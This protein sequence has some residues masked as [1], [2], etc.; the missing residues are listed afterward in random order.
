MIDR[1]TKMISFRMSWDE[2]RALQNACTTV[3]VRNLSELARGAM[4]QLIA[5]GRNGAPLYDQVC[6]LR[7]QM[8]L[9]S[10]E[11][12]RIIERID[13]QEKVLTARFSAGAR[14]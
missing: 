5:S 12:K 13:R 14:I 3:G 6:E 1:R 8:S 11:V 2:Y 7:G 10:D 9:L 4:Q